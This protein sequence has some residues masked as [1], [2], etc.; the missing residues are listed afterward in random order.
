M[1]W[2]I[3][4]IDTGEIIFEHED[5]ERCINLALLIKRIYK[6]KELLLCVI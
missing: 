6:D 4:N 3:I 5:Q 2:Y 1:K